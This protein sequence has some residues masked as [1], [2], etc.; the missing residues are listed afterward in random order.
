MFCSYYYYITFSPASESLRTTFH[1][2]VKMFTL[3]IQVH[4]IK[5]ITWKIIAIKLPLPV[6]LV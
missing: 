6:G 3:D 5:A 1:E 2:A 4:S